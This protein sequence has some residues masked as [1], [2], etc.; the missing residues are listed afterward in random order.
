M[1]LRRLLKALQCFILLLAFFAALN[2]VLDVPINKLGMEKVAAANQTYL[3]QSMDKAVSGF[4]ILSGIKTGLA[5]IEGS[6]VGIGF[7]LQIGDIVQSVYDYVDIAWKTAL[8]GGTVIL[9]TR[10]LLQTV[11]LIDHWFLALTF[12]SGFLVVLARWIFPRWVRANRLMKDAT[13]F[14]AVCAAVFYIVFPFS[15]AGAAF[16]SQKITG[17]LIDES[18]RSFEGIKEEFSVESINRH[19]FSS[20]AAG[21]E[22]SIAGLILKGKMAKIKEAIKAQAEYFKD[23]SRNIAIWTLQLIAG[24]LFDSIIFPVIFF[25]FLFVIV[26][27]ALLYLFEDRRQQAF[28]EDLRAVLSKLQQ[29]KPERP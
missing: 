1:K 26:K 13:F 18:Q 9:I 17:P 23:K 25:I 28:G 20:D 29:M 12:G 8:A 2:G 11:D 27:G 16:I 5:V 6:E 19:I 22:S 3:K 15:I 4:L 14:L 7:S 24:Y 21:E 10:L